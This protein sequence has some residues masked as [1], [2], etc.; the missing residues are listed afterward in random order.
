MKVDHRPKFKT[1]YYKA[2]Q[3]QIKENLDDLFRYFLDIT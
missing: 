2:A 1:Q 3:R